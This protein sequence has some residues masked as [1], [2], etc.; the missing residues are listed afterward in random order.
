[1]VDVDNIKIRQTWIGEETDAIA[2]DMNVSNDDAFMLLSGSILLDCPAD[3][4]IAEDIVDGG[5]DKQIDF[6]HIED[7][8]DKGY[9]SIIIAQCK[10]GNG[11]SS[12]IAIQIKNGLDWV[13]EVPKSEIENIPNTTFKQKIFEIRELRQAYGPANIDVSVYHISKG[14]KSQLSDEYLAEAEKLKQKYQSLGFRSFKF[15]QLGSHELVELLNYGIRASRTVDIDIPVIYDV[16]RPSLMQFAQGDTKSIV[17][18]VS[19]QAL[20]VAASQEPRDSIFDLNVRPYYGSGGKV[21]KEI[22]STCTDDQSSRFWFLNNGVTMVCDSFDFNSDPD[23]PQIKVL[24]AQIVNGCQTTVTLREAYEKNQLREDTKVL[25]RI[26]STD[27]PNLVERITL[28]TNNQNKITDRDLRANDPVQRDI[29]KIM[30]DKY[31]YF[32]ERKNK[33]HRHLRGS[34]KKKVVHSPKAAQAYLA[35]VRFKPAN[36]RGYLN[37]IWSDFYTEIFENASVVDLLVA[38]KIHQYCHIKALEGKQLENVTSLERDC[39]VYGVFHIA[40]AMGFAL[41]EDKWGHA[42]TSKIEELFTNICEGFDLETYYIDALHIVMAMREKD[43]DD[44]QVLAMYFKNT[45]SHRRL[46]SIL[47]SDEN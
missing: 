41:V 42:N 12:N 37:A 46:N 23:A 25:L 4:I 7:D 30:H 34:D 3:E 47:R 2:S 27:N 44:Y 10:N 1:M 13:F 14:D 16:N 43:Q 38:Y 18:T 33:Q 29:E 40:R 45:H 28:T 24:N 32:Y 9:A 19:G 35:I 20:A 22:W 17:C 36:A 15:D 26:Y 21:N 8:Q 11:F 6:I 39:R 31:Q 5:Q